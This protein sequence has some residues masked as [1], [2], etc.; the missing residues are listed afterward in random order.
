VRRCREAPAL[1]G[2]RASGKPSFR[3]VQRVRGPEL[4]DPV[5]DNATLE[6]TGGAR[7]GMSCDL[8]SVVVRR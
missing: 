6:A 5:V 8:A 2:E 1:F 4:F 3:S 7:Q